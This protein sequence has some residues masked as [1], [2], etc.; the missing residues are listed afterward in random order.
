MDL[1]TVN[2]VAELL[3]VQEETIR[4]WLRSGK[5][6]GV[7]LGNR[8]RVTTNDLEKFLKELNQ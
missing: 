3:K 8:W 2:E 6:K 1:M 4:N 7:K 5:L